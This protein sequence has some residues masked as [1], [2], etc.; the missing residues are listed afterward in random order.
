[1]ASIR[2]PDDGVQGAR[3]RTKKRHVE[4]VTRL[5]TKNVWQLL[6]WAF[7]VAKA[8]IRKQLADWIR[9]R[10]GARWDESCEHL[11]NSPVR[12]FR[13][14]SEDVSS[15]PSTA[16]NALDFEQSAG[17]HLHRD[18][19]QNQRGLCVLT[20]YMSILSDRTFLHAKSVSGRR[21]ARRRTGPIRRVAPA[22][23]RAGS[24]RS[25]RARRR[26]AWCWPPARC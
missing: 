8:L 10:A 12:R 25:C 1:M 14:P 6:C 23:S 15:L 20:S 22:G 24:C 18:S 13:S 7:I 5:P 9:A 19:R 16:S 2:T 4:E 11:I 3:Q 17:R 21:G 26:T